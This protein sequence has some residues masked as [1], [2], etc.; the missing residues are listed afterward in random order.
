MLA[1]NPTVSFDPKDWNFKNSNGQ[2]IK[3]EKLTTEEQLVLI[4]HQIDLDKLKN[5]R[6][7]TFK[8]KITL[9]SLISSSSLPKDLVPIL[10]DAIFLVSIEFMRDVI[11]QKFLETLDKL[12]E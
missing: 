10:Q 12:G 8:H 1:N 3:G 2:F 5:I 9:Q 6:R 7:N 11:E 4:D